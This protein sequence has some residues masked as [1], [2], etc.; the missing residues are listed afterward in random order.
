MTAGI[1]QVVARGHED[2]ILTEDPQITLFKTI[3][4]RHT[5]FS[6]TEYDLKFIN[7]L[8]FGKIGIVTIEKLAD[9]VHRLFL[10]IKLP[11]IDICYDK[12]TAEIVQEK[13]G[14]KWDGCDINDIEQLIQKEEEKIAIKTKKYKKILKAVKNNNSNC[15]NVDDFINYLISNLLKYDNGYDCYKIIEDQTTNNN[16]MHFH[17]IVRLVKEEFVK[18]ITSGSLE[19][20]NLWCI[21][22]SYDSSLDL[23]KELAIKNCRDNYNRF[24]DIVKSRNDSTFCF[25]K[26]TNNWIN[27]SKI[28]SIFPETEFQKYM[29][30]YPEL[31]ADF[32]DKLDTLFDEFNMEHFNEL[33]SEQYRN[34]YCL[35]ML[36]L[37]LLDDVEQKSDKIKEIERLRKLF[38]VDNNMIQKLNNILKQND[39]NNDKKLYIAIFDNNND[40]LTSFISIINDTFNI[41]YSSDSKVLAINEIIQKFNN[42]YKQLYKE[43][44]GELN[45]DINRQNLLEKYDRYKNSL[46]DIEQCKELKNYEDTVHYIIDHYISSNT[47]SEIVKKNMLEK[48]YTM[49]KDIIEQFNQTTMWNK[50]K[51]MDF[52]DCTCENEVYDEIKNMIVSKTVFYKIK[53]LKKDTIEET[54]STISEYFNNFGVD[55]SKYDKLREMIRRVG[56]KPKFSWIRNIGHYIIKYIRIKLNDQ[57]V[58]VRYGEWMFIWHSLTRRMQKERGYNLLIGN[59]PDLYTFNSEPKDEYEMIIPLP[60]WFCDEIGASLPLV[61]M[62]RMDIKMYVELRSFEEVSRFDE[63]THFRKQPKLECSVIGEYIYVDSSER[64]KMVNSSLEYLIEGVQYN[65]DLE[66]VDVDENGIIVADYDFSLLTREIFW[67]LQRKEFIDGSNC[68]YST[69]NVKERK[70]NNYGIDYNTGEGSIVKRVQIKFN[71][72]IREHFKDEVFYNSIQPYER[73]YASPPNG[74][75]CYSFAIH[76]ENSMQPSGVLNTGLIQYFILEIE[77]SEPII[78][79]L[80]NKKTRLRLATY[81]LG[82][83]ILRVTNGIAGVLFY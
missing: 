14:I 27:L 24:E 71:E 34:V 59:I 62:N 1:L 79:L 54:C 6:K 31:T 25:Y 77:L 83:S 3:Y 69:G 55:S 78:E 53:E 39:N 67:V 44:I 33:E 66:F 37:I 72:R 43:L 76:P 9:L 40:W 47:I 82:N 80:K 4:R 36:P 81:S 51:E 21:E 7:R 41:D 42:Y 52:K 20:F 13:F 23:P 32:Y 17:D 73:H 8:D 12:L 30:K 68:T 18:C 49:I 70:Y 75:Y 50:I 22:N 65:G 35:N 19:L 38:T 15:N 48:N 10:V 5:N 56:K 28:K 58:D 29:G 63:Y 16:I 64:E 74:V 61:A 46:L 57:V 11:K 60:L 45:E 2:I 26:Y